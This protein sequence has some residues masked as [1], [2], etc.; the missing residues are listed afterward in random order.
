MTEQR[1]VLVT[2]AGGMLGTDL[3][4]VLAQAGWRVVAAD[5]GEFD[6]TDATATREFVTSCRPSVVINCAAYTAVDQAETDYHAAFRVN[7][8]GA[9]SVAEAAAAVGAAMVQISTDYVFDGSKEGPYREDDQPNPINAYGF[10][11]LLGELAVQVT[12]A[13]HYVVRTAWLHGIHGKSFPRTM[14]T[15]AQSGQPLR[16]V[17]DQVGAPTYTGHLAQALAVIISKP[18][19]G[20]YHAV[21]Q[22]CCSW[23]ECACEVLRAAGLPGQGLAP[24]ITPIPSSEYPT[25]APRPRNSL[26]DTSRL[27]RVYGHRLPS[28]QEGVAEFIAEWRRRASG[29][30]EPQP[31]P[32]Q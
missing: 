11:K 16:V 23:Y 31:C 5:V 24:D 14:L 32:T 8:G 9:R 21:S 10:S 12:L 26:L 13:E 15:L 17:N 28:W 3:C 30:P 4:R 1:T 29:P 2:G 19:Y 7:H 22:G 25:A 20:V 18:C 27:A 6:I